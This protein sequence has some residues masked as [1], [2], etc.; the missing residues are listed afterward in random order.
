MGFP[1]ETEAE[2]EELRRFVADYRFER[3]GVFPYSLEPGT[4]ARLS[5]PRSSPS[6]SHRLRA[7]PSRMAPAWPE[8]PPPSIVASMS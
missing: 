6:T 7:M 2:F 3:L 8:I 1:G 4:P 5:A